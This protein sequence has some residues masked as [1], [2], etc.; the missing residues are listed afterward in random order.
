[1]MDVSPDTRGQVLD[2]SIY[3]LPVGDEAFLKRLRREPGRLIIISDN[4][5]NFPERPARKANISA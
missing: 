4:R 2:N 1:M 3:A 5:D